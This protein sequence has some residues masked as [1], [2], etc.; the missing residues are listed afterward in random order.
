[1]I[2][3]ANQTEKLAKITRISPA[4]GAV[5]W[6]RV[7]FSAAVVWPRARLGGKDSVEERAGLGAGGAVADLPVAKPDEPPGPVCATG[8]VGGGQRQ[9]QRADQRGERGQADIGPRPFAGRVGVRGDQAAAPAGPPDTALRAGE[10]LKRRN[11]PSS[12]PQVPDLSAA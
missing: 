8:Q 10:L 3:S 9:G 1:M 11:R 7:L 6:L 2:V 4:R 5:T 12:C